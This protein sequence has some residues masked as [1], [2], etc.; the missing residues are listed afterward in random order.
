MTQ[1][2]K[3]DDFVPLDETDLA[4]METY[5]KGPYAKEITETEKEIKKMRSSIDTIR[6][7]SS[8]DTGFL[9]MNEW[10][11]EKDRKM[12]SEPFLYIGNCDKILPPVPNEKQHYIVSL[13]HAGKYVVE[14]SKNVAPSD[15]TENLRVGLDRRVL[16]ITLPL[17]PRIDPIVTT[18][19]VEEKPDVTYADIGGCKEQI[20]KLKEII[21]M[22]LMHPERF[23]K[24]GIDPPKGV[25]FYGP[26]GTGKT[27]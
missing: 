14:L 19:Q 21:E 1:E 13:P 3:D 18:M 26:P 17:P 20:E 5:S 7:V 24:L 11:L 15:I 6:G 27:L 16:S 25:L 4:I 2:E 23:E 22:P 8:S 9:P 12:L 10:D